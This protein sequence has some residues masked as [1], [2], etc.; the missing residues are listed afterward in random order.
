MLRQD[1]Q[2]KTKCDRV[3]HKI[4]DS[5]TV[6]QAFSSK[7]IMLSSTK[8]LSTSAKRSRKASV[9]LTGISLFYFALRIKKR[10]A[11]DV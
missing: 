6:L 8:T 11:A 10:Y 7:R 5:H 1:S 3:P 9:K 4:S 2:A